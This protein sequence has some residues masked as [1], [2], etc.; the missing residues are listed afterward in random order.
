ME[1]VQPWL[2]VASSSGS[3]GQRPYLMEFT[4]MNMQ[5]SI[6]MN[7]KSLQSI[8]AEEFSQLSV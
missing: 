2:Q 3:H 6:T 1:N 8:A 7:K 5:F 4:E